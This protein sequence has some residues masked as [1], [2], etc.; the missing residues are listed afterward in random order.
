MSEGYWDYHDSREWMERTAK[1]N[2][3]PL[4][5][6]AALT[7]G[8]QGKEL[9]PNHP[10]TAQEQAEQAYECY[11]LGASIIHIHARCED[12][13][14]KPTQDPDRYREINSLIRDKCP[15]VIINNT[16]GGGPGMPME[17]RMRSVEAEPEMCSLTMGPQGSRLRLAERPPYRPE[18]VFITEVMPANFDNIEV[19]AQAMA[20]RDIK[21]EMEIYHDGLFPVLNHIIRKGLVKKPY[22]VQLIMGTSTGAEA[23]PKTLIHMMEL[24]PKDTMASVISIGDFQTPMITL[25]ILL[26]LHV[27][28]GMEDNPYYEP[29]VPCTGNGQLVERVVRISRELGRR[30]A[31]PKEA[32]Q[33]LELS[34]VPRRWR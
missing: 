1:R 13:P 32:R 6:T 28:T 26:G 11:K 3:P 31:T 14:T 12:N 17:E 21:P 27:R 29:G 34:E 20:E 25:G 24:V 30:I 4:I 23:S 2:L 15:D 22:W 33:M 7:G 8:V 19:F 16:T 18:P 10:E 5:I 9:N